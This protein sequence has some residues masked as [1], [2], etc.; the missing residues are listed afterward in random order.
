MNILHASYQWAKR[1]KGSVTSVHG[2][3]ERLDK[4][5]VAGNLVEE[6]KAFKAVA[7]K[8]SQGCVF[9]RQ[10]EEEG[11]VQ[12]SHPILP[13]RYQQ[14]KQSKWNTKD[15]HSPSQAPPEVAQQVPAKVCE[16]EY[17]VDGNIYHH[18]R[19]VA[20]RGK[21]GDLPDCEALDESDWGISNVLYHVSSTRTLDQQQVLLLPWTGFSSRIYRRSNST[22]VPP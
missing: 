12:R 6:V 14:S 22:S 13:Y 16:Q 21:A 4:G 9:Q 18:D 7:G 17:D 10:E 5:G 19:A 2:M 8:E 11:N 15:K 1:S 3:E 20:C